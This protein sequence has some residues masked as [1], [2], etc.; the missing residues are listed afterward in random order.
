MNEQ[1]RPIVIDVCIGRCHMSLNLPIF[2]EESYLA[3]MRKVF[4]WA[5]EE[6]RR[7]EEMFEKLA[8]FFPEWEQ[9]LRDQL[10]HAGA[11]LISAKKDA[12]DKRRV[13]ASWGSALEERIAQARNALT[14]AKRAKKQNR[15]P[16]D[17]VA[18]YQAAFD[19]VNGI[20]TAP[21]QAAKEVTRIAGVIK[22]TQ[23][24]LEH[25][26]KIINAY[27]KLKGI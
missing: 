22:R 17:K 12:E 9:A 15:I 26:G 3:D 6:P 7:N 5:M 10:D 8:R 25:C 11:D 18:E 13:K 19:A 4:K 16:S 23:A 20:K 27:T 21:I 24:V 14:R 2:F 1:P